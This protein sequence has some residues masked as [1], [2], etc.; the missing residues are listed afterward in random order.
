MDISD[1]DQMDWEVVEPL[2]PGI[3]D[4]SSWSS[5]DN[6]VRRCRC[7]RVGFE[8]NSN[9]IAVRNW[10]S[11]NLQTRGDTFPVRFPANRPV[12]LYK[13]EDNILRFYMN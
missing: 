3:L 13:N 4:V 9:N 8:A 5:T 2:A 12:D 11:G 7:R 1:D 10:W 6:T